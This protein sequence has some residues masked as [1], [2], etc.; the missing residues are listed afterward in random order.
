MKRC[1]RVAQALRLWKGPKASDGSVPRVRV[2]S[3]RVRMQ[4]SVYDV[5]RVCESRCTAGKQIEEMKVVYPK[6]TQTVCV[7]TAE[8]EEKTEMV[9]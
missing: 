9:W 7:E 6:A 2:L 1:E 5:K 8:C 3:G 4:C